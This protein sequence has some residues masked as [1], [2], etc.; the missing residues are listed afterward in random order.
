M[1]TVRLSCAAVFW[2]STEIY[3]SKYLKTS[4]LEVQHR[5]N[6]KSLRYDK[7]FTTLYVRPSQTTV[8]QRSLLSMCEGACSSQIA[9]CHEH[10]CT[11]WIWP[12]ILLSFCES[13]YGVTLICPPPAFTRRELI[14]GSQWVTSE[15]ED[16]L[17][18]PPYLTKMER[19]CLKIYGAVERAKC[20][21][22]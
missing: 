4:G 17:S 9:V 22:C 2:G 11:W 5:N 6:W 7:Y 12:W 10:C 3:V 13:H 21:W 19:S 1:M 20:W 14:K 8:E 15:K 18:T 16:L